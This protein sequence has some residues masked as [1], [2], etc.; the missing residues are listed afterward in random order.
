[1]DLVDVVMYFGYELVERLLVAFG[2]RPRLMLA[3]AIAEDG[4]GDSYHLLGGK[5]VQCLADWE[6]GDETGPVAGGL[7]FHYRALDGVEVEVEGRAAAGVDVGGDE[8]IVGEIQ[9]IDH[10]S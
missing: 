1:M 9:H 4:L 3:G 2:H 6:F 5:V 10:S 8:D 7:V